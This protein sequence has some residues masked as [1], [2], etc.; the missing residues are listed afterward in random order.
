MLGT[1]KQITLKRHRPPLLGATCVRKREISDARCATGREVTCPVYSVTQ[2]PGLHRLG[3]R[4]AAR[5]APICSKPHRLQTGRSH[6][7]AH[8]AW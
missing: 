6:D 3:P 1:K 2:V 5:S 7:V 8:L 4:P